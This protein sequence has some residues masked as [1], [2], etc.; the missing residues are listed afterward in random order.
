MQTAACPKYLHAACKQSVNR[1]QQQAVAACT[2][3]VLVDM[4]R[5]DCRSS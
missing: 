2:E 1:Q 5:V 4:Q 3:L